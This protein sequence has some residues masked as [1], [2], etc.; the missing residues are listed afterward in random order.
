MASEIVVIF[1]K[2][3][4]WFS[5][6]FKNVPSDLVTARAALNTAVP[7]FEEVVAVADPAL[8]AVIDPIVTEIQTD[9]GTVA[10]MLQTGSTSTLSGFLTA[11]KTNFSTLLSEAKITDAA[12]V[13]K[14]NSF[15]AVIDSIAT[16]L[17]I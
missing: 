1:D 17:G 6:V 4:S 11:I 16:A 9:L 13:A 10:G 12:S 8:A 7:L 15:L 5:K 2:I 3:K 14:A